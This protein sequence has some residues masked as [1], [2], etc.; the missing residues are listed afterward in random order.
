MKEFKIIPTLTN[1]AT[2]S[3]SITIFTYYTPFILPNTIKAKI[4]DI[5]GTL[6]GVNFIE[7]ELTIDMINHPENIDYII[8]DEG[9]LIVIAN[10]GDTNKYSVN[11]DGDL[12]WVP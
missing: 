1:L 11:V 6:N 5:V 10:T 8:N 9:E 4:Q 2:S 12:I 7:N 3:S